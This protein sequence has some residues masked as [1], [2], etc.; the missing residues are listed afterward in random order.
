MCVVSFIGKHQT[1]FQN[2]YDILHFLLQHVRN[3]IALYLCLHWVISVLKNFS[4]FNRYAIVSHVAFIFIS[5]MGNDE[6]LS[7]H[8]LICHLCN[9]FCLF[10][11]FFFCR[12]LLK[13]FY[14]YFFLFIFIFIFILFVVDFVIH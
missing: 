3:P 9:V 6:H 8:I 10:S 11:F 5:L 4:H 7:S 13:H 14:F 2:T 1:A 12:P